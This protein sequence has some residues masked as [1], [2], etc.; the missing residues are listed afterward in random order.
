MRGLA[1]LEAAIIVHVR[2]D[3]GHH[4]ARAELKLMRRGRPAHASRSGSRRSAPGCCASCARAPPP[5][6]TSKS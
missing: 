4:A 1:A 2:G 6:R 3:P 5:S